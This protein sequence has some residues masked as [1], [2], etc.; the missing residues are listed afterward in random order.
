M[1]RKIDLAPPNLAHAAIFS[2][3]YRVEQDPT[4][5]G[6]LLTHAAGTPAQN[7]NPSPRNAAAVSGL[8]PSS[9]P[10]KSSLPTLSSHT[11]DRDFIRLASC[12]DP[13]SSLGLP[14]L[15]TRGDLTGSWEGRFSFFDFD[16]YRDML[17][18]RMRSLYEGPFG[19]QPQVWKIE[20][21][22]V[23]LEKGQ[24]LGGSGPVV[25]AGFEVGPPVTRPGVGMSHSQQQVQAAATSG[26]GSGGLG[27]GGSSER[28]QSRRRTSV[29]VDGSE[30]D[31]VPRAAKRAR[32]WQ[33]E[34]FEEEEDDEP[35]G[36]Y[37]ILLSGTV[38]LAFPSPSIF[39]AHY[40]FLTRVDRVIPL[41]ASS[42]FEVV[43]DPGTECSLSSRSTRP[44]VEGGGSIEEC[45]SVEVSSG[46]GGTLIR[47]LFPSFPLFVLLRS[48]PSCTTLMLPCTLSQPG[49]PQWL[50][51]DLYHVSPLAEQAFLTRS[52]SFF[53]VS[54]FPR[55]I[56][57]LFVLF[58]FVASLSVTVLCL[59]SASD[60]E[61]EVRRKEGEPVDFS[62]SWHPRMSMTTAASP[63]CRL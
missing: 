23:K 25:N 16:S 40:S 44:T 34:A 33:G 30:A 7:P 21:R 18:G 11:H 26:S 55:C 6:E 59:P 14:K 15:Y 50:R 2:F 12:I 58:S 38:R 63:P 49:R 52:F 3:F 19:D 4:A 24:K 54:P 62:S 20:E 13:Y 53:P 36:D 47:A 57:P 42:S 27:G 51:G 43:F 39:L 22:V 5:Q 41:G 45:W 60:G 9:R 48:H 32:S 35:D 10:T 17:G 61:R 8:T 28:A 29:D 31:G 56:F 46:V 37:E 1:G